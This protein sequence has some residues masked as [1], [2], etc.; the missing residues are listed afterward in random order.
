MPAVLWV[1]LAVRVVRAGLVGTTPSG[2][3]LML[4]ATSQG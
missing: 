4:D 2:V 1:P 3:E